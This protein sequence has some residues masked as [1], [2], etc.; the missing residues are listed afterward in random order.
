MWHNEKENKLVVHSTVD[1]RRWVDNIDAA[2]T[3]LIYCTL[4]KRKWY[5][6]EMKERRKGKKEEKKEGCVKLDILLCY[7]LVTQL[8]TPNSGPINRT[9][10]ENRSQ[11]P[12]WYDPVSLHF[13]SPDPTLTSW[14]V[15]PFVFP[16]QA[17]LH[18]TLLVIPCP[19]ISF[20]P[21]Y[22][23]PSFPNPH[24]NPPDFPYTF[25][26]PSGLGKSFVLFSYRPR[27]I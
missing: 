20:V 26:I 16:F 8:Q 18:I 22:S 21:S 14:Y 6:K 25:T 23:S 19:P 1:Y 27:A 4:S 7:D 17:L 24:L 13:Q 9:N 2:T 5:H 15:F 3:T 10:S 11:V 12:H